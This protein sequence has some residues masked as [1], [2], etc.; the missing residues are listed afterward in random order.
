MFADSALVFR[1]T[2]PRGTRNVNRVSRFRDARGASEQSP[3][4]MLPANEGLAEL[5]NGRTLDGEELGAVT[6]GV[7]IYIGEE[8]VRAHVQLGPFRRHHHAHAFLRGL[9]QVVFGDHHLGFLNTALLFPSFN[10]LDGA[11]REA[12][13]RKVISHLTADSLVRV[14]G[15]ALLLTALAG[16]AGPEVFVLLS[17]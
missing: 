15:H 7:L 11:C 14:H 2:W 10:E 6:G 3:E 1:L 9:L 5:D 12:P 8:R 4:N 17:C 16:D 13:H